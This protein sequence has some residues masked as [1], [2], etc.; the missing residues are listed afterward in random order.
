[1]N[2][3]NP[4]DYI[5]L[6]STIASNHNN[7]NNSNKSFNV[8]NTSRSI[9]NMNTSGINLIDSAYNHSDNN[10]SLFKNDLE[11]MGSIFASSSVGTTLNNNEKRKFNLTKD[12]VPILIVSNGVKQQ[13]Y[14]IQNGSSSHLHLNSNSKLNQSLIDSSNEKIKFRLKHYEYKN[15]PDQSILNTTDSKTNNNNN[16]SFDRTVTSAKII[17]SGLIDKIKL[18]TV[19]LNNNSNSTIITN[20]NNNKVCFVFFLIYFFARFISFLSI[21]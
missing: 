1:M 16:T 12:Q 8:L 7:H 2:N 10:F 17:N 6:N 14:H 4:D 3:V 20:N 21:I 13:N 9:K 5:D 15:N 18:K 19:H 11:E